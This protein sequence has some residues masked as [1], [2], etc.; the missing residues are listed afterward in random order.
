MAKTVPEP[1]EN[2]KSLREQVFATSWRKKGFVSTPKNPN[3]WGLLM[4]IG[5]AQ[6]V[7]SLVCMIDGSVNLYFGTGGGITGS[8]ERESVRM[9]AEEFI[10]VAETFLKQFNPTKNYP[11]PDID[12]VRFY[13]FTYD[14]IE[15]AQ[16][17]KNMADEKHPFF[18][19][20]RSGHEVIAAMK[21]ITETNPSS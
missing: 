21:S 9:K 7:V 4:E 20:L 5:T 15:T 19:L 10:Q 6:T 17:N 11:L 14:G 16:D 2:Y 8:G 3:I 1:A 13:A 12:R 18:P